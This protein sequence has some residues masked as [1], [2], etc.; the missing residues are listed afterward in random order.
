MIV[1]LLDVYRD[2]VALFP[3]ISGWLKSLASPEAAIWYVLGLL[4][5]P[6][7]H[8]I[9]IRVGFVRMR[10]RLSRKIKSQSRRHIS[11]AMRIF[12]EAYPK[13]PKEIRKEER[14]NI[15]DVLA[16]IIEIGGRSPTT[17][18]KR[19]RCEVDASWRE[20]F[21]SKCRKI[22]DPRLQNAMAKAFIYEAITPG[23]FA[24]RDID[25]LANMSA[26]NWETFTTICG[27]ACCIGGRIIPVILNYEDDVYKMADLDT[28]A[29]DSVV[30]VGLV[31]RG[32]TGDI[33][34]LAMPMQGLPVAYFE[35]DEFIV[36]ALPN[37]ISRTYLGRTRVRPDMLDTHINVGV[38]D[39]TQAGRTLGF[40]TSCAGVDGFLDH[41]R[42][43]WEVYLHD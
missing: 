21:V 43:Q 7:F 39:F 15:L 36:K 4:T 22:H 30:A 33:Y 5:L 37:P 1:F 2:A 26:E 41:L 8:R 29:I 16:K 18:W 12:S 42:Q 28:E 35:E 14:E 34:M 6:L 10:R 24:Y 31:T 9:L 11:F 20:F 32:G 38:V 17:D 27:F 23:R 25:M 19:L 13:A 3:V 40:L